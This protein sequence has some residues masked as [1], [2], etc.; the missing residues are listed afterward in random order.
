MWNMINITIHAVFI[1]PWWDATSPSSSTVEEG[2]NCDNC[3]HL[4]HL[5]HL[6]PWTFLFLT[7]KEKKISYPITNVHVYYDSGKLTILYFYS[8][9]EH[10]QVALSTNIEEIKII[11]SKLL[12][13]I[14]TTNQ[15]THGM[16]HVFSNLWS[17]FPLIFPYKRED[18]KLSF[19]IHH[20][21]TT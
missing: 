14:Y 21:T 1:Y 8:P 4:H 17:G 20:I 11:L 6:H 10:N 3:H 9:T 7:I 19:Q 18:R 15:N 12:K 16:R 5:H 13:V 2:D